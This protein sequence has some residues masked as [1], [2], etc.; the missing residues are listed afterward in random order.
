[1]KKIVSSK[2]AKVVV[3]MPIIIASIQIVKADFYG[4]VG[5]GLVGFDTVSRSGNVTVI[6]RE[7]DAVPMA[8]G[9]LGYQFTPTFAAEASIGMFHPGDNYDQFY[10]ASIDGVARYSTDS[11]FRLFGKVGVGRLNDSN[12][13]KSG[14]SANR[15]RLGA[16]ALFDL[17]GNDSIRVEYEHFGRSSQDNGPAASMTGLT[18]GFQRSFR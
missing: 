16:G 3:M 5:G 11:G 13:L 6:T 14:G 12:P 8:K 17:K 2:L 1:M 10:S 7:K 18:V 4:A 15:L 9:L